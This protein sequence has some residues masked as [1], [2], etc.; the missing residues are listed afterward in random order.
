MIIVKVVQQPSLLHHLTDEI[1]PSTTIIDSGETIDALGKKVEQL[2]KL[3]H[4]LTDQLVTHTAS[5]TS[6]NNSIGEIRTTELNTSISSISTF[7][8]EWTSVIE[9]IV[10][11]TIIRTVESQSEEVRE[12][13]NEDFVT[14]LRETIL[15]TM[16]PE[17]QNSIFEVIRETSGKLATIVELPS[18]MDR[19][20]Y[21]C[22]L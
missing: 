4:Q 11:K 6:L 5:L 12:T 18:R 14:K 8:P 9:K 3:V 10:E 20:T 19:T 16:V 17:L 13:N 7:P 22:S 1:L 15:E 21:G 2:T